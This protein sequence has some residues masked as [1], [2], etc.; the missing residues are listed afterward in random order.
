MAKKKQ[1]ATQVSKGITHTNPNR[2]GRRISKE[3]RREYMQNGMRQHNQ[4]LAYMKG[5]KVM[6]TIPNPN[7]NE[8]NKR[9]IR[10]P[11]NEVWKTVRRK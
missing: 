4:L 8:T 9:F 7:T 6:L 1:R 2:L 10:V 5:K 11:A 3:L